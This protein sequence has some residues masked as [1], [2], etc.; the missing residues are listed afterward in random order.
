[1]RTSGQCMA[2]AFRYGGGYWIPLVS[3]N[4]LQGSQFL[5]VIARSAAQT[6]TANGADDIRKKSRGRTLKATMG[7][8]VTGWL[9]GIAR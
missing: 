8:F 1:M 5:G 4:I 9:H 7:R 6:S 3:N 2:C